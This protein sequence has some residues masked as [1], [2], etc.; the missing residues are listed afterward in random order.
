MGQLQ[1]NWTVSSQRAHRELSWQASKSSR[2]AGR[3]PRKIPRT[4]RRLGPRSDYTRAWGAWFWFPRSAYWRIDHEGLDNIRAAGR[5]LFVSNHRGFMQL[6]AV[7]HISLILKHRGRIPRFLITHSLPRPPFLVNFLTQPGGVTASRENTARLFVAENLI[8]I[9]PEVF[10]APSAPH[11]RAYQLRYLS[12]SGFARMAIENEAPVIADAVVVHAEIF[13][14]LG[15]IDWS[16]ATREW[17]WPYLP[18]APMFAV[19]PVPLPSSRHV[20]VLPPAPLQGLRPSDAEHA[21]LVKGFSHH[22]QHLLQQNIDDMLARRKH[23]FWGKVLDGSDST[24]KWQAQ[25]A[26][27]PASYVR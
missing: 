26:A 24:A 1:Y 9:L 17:G 12:K 22:I 11:K 3:S 19:V 10:A 4:I 20:N 18:I 5:A 23:I 8:A 6:N 13:P 7:M 15:R 27:P 21:G 2:K 25:P 14:I 16:Y